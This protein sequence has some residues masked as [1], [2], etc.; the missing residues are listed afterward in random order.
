MKEAFWP[1]DLRLSGFGEYTQ[2]KAAAMNG[3][4]DGDPDH[5]GDA[6]LFQT[7]RLRRH[8]DY[9]AVEAAR[10]LKA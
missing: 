8:P 5:D 6:A 2:I 10:K 1:A 4:I 9:F 3:W 7:R